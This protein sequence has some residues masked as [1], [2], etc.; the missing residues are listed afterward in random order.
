MILVNA[1]SDAK[2]INRKTLQ[3]LSILIAPFA[4]HLAEDIRCKTL[5]NKFSI[6]TQ[7]T[8]PTF[9]EKLLV[10]DTVKMAV[11]FN[12]KVR[13]TIQIPADATQQQVMEII[14][15]DQSL[16]SRITS[17]PKKVIYVPGKIVNIIL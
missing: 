4:P 11:Q 10:E 1:L 3:T 16:A 14:K 7:A 6:F 15:Q 13:G 8:R 9:D 2:I 12:G 5:G 17:E